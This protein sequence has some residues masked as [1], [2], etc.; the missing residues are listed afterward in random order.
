MAIKNSF[1]DRMRSALRTLADTID[2]DG[3]ATDTV[4]T[5]HEDIAEAVER[6]AKSYTVP[7]DPPVV[8][9]DGCLTVSVDDEDKFSVK[10]ADIKEALD[11]GFMVFLSGGAYGVI[12]SYSAETEYYAVYGYYFTGD[13]IEAHTPTKN[14]ATYPVIYTASTQEENSSPK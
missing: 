2:P 7:V 8:H 11:G 1:Q 10:Y 9:Y 6:V 13:S 5:Y 4:D 14:S 3:T 12:T